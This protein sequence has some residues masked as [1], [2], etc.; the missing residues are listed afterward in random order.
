MSFLKNLLGQVSSKN[1]RKAERLPAPKLA[2]FYWTNASPAE[3]SIRDISI[4]GLYLLTEERWY[5][6][7]L[8]MMTL[9]KKDE[10]PNAP[11]ESISVQ[12]RAVRWGTDGVGLQFILPDLGNRHPGQSLLSGGT[13]RKSLE[14]FLAGFRPDQGRAIVD[15]VGTSQDKPS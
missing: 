14:K 10:G 15:S 8:V 11:V 12:S 2:A 4:T 6:G 3:H 1:R 13:D 9:Q 7:T 5:P